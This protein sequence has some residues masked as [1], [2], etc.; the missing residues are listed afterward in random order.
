M[1]NIT[2]EFSEGTLEA[3]SELGIDGETEARN[4][5]TKAFI[6]DIKHLLDKGELGQ[7]QMIL[8][9]LIENQKGEK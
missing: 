7:A 4:A 8:E 5:V 3:L 2:I 6:D 9:S 1:S